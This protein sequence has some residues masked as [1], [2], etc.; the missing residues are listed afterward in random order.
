MSEKSLMSIHANMH[1]H[2]GYWT[3]RVT[4]EQVDTKGSGEVSVSIRKS[5]RVPEANTE[6]DQIWLC[7]VT[8]LHAV[9]ANGSIGRIST[10]DWPP[11]F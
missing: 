2:Y 4:A 1:E 9:E 8:L 10:A 7:L 6:I 5:T 3:L 11:L